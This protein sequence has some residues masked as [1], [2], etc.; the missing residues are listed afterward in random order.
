MSVRKLSRSLVRAVASA[1]ESAVHCNATVA[2]RLPVLFD[3]ALPPSPGAL[4]EWNRA[5]TEKLEAAWEG[6][7]VATAEWQAM[8]FR[9]AFRLPT[10]LG[11]ATDLMSAAA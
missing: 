8:L 3:G 5:Y 9:S 2:A 6:A 1:Q 10:P 4:A 7:V 11:F